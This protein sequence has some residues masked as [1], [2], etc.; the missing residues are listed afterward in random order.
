MPVKPPQTPLAVLVAGGLDEQERYRQVLEAGVPG[1]SLR[2]RVASGHD[3]ADIENISG[4]SAESH[5]AIV[6]GTDHS[7]ENLHSLFDAVITTDDDLNRFLARAKNFERRRHAHRLPPDI[8][9]IMSP[10][11]PTWASTAARIGTRVAHILANHSIDAM[12]DH[13]GSTSV[14][15]LAAKNI[16]DLQISLEDLDMIDWCD[17]DLRNAGFVNVQELAPDSPGV[18]HDNARGPTTSPDQWQ[19]RLY[20]GVDEAQRGSCT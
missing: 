13:I 16:I 4:A 2:T 11:S 1:I 15:G 3:G 12:V 9:P 7:L 14:P 5:F 19:K 18:S 8:A 20:A 17:I 10:W 6:D